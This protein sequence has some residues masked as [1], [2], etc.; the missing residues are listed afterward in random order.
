MFVSAAKSNS[1]SGVLCLQLSNQILLSKG[2]INLKRSGSVSLSLKFTIGYRTTREQLTQLETRIKGY[3]KRHSVDW[4]PSVSITVRTVFGL[5]GKFSVQMGNIS[6][7]CPLSQQQYFHTIST[8]LQ[9]SR[10]ISQVEDGSVSGPLNITIG[11]SHLKTWMDSDVSTAKGQLIHV[12]V[13]YMQVSDIFGCAPGLHRVMRAC[14]R[15]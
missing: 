15:L 4:K 6:L 7:A 12:I 14:D 9:L 3:L 1:P 8:A 5:F 13:K 11:V 2:I 10:G